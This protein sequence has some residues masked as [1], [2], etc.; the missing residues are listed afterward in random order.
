MNTYAPTFFLSIEGEE[1]PLDLRNSITAFSFEDNDEQLDQLTI[2]V[3][4]ENIE[5][6]DNALLQEN[7]IA[8][9]RWGYVDALGPQRRMLIKEID[10]DFPSDGIPIIVLKAYDQAVTLAS[11]EKQRVW[12]KEA[13]GYLYS[14]IAEAIAAEAGLSPVIEKTSGCHLRVAQS[15]Q[16]DANFLMELSKQAVNEQG[17]ANY[18]FYV[19]DNELHFH[20]RPLDTPPTHTF[21]YRGQDST[22][23]SFKPKAQGQWASGAGKGTTA[24][25]VDPRK[26]ETV[27]QEVVNEKSTRTSLGRKTYQVDGKTGRFVP[28]YERSESFHEEPERDPAKD[29]AEAKFSE[30]E[31]RQ[32][33]ASV[34]V[35]GDPTLRAKTNIEIQGVGRK[36]GGLYYVT[37]CQH[38]IDDNGYQCK[39]ELRRNAVGRGAGPNTDDT[40]GKHN[41]T[42][43]QSTPPPPPDVVVDAN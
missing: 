5:F 9:A 33:E 4:N 25:G 3:V 30:T 16:S 12:Q 10:Y 21:V 26:M 34:I 32:V 40:V 22:L 20:T 7:N 6:T 43:D 18:A 35:V 11:E 19:Q 17:V 2:T 42:G 41:D 37:S 15:N 23:L 29:K 14:E 8:I 39:L 36:F 31:M 27:S 24:I 1:V 28:F 38:T 13:P